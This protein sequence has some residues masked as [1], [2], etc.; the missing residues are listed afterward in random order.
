M[1]IDHCHETGKVRGLLCSK[2]NIAL[3]NFD[4]DIETLKRAISYL[5]LSERN[6]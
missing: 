4:D 6:L 5:S 1:F 3:G 2:C